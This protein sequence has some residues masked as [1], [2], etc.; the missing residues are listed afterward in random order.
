MATENLKIY[1][2][3]KKKKKTGQIH[4]LKT[5]KTAMNS[6][7]PEHTY[8]KFLTP[9]IENIVNLHGFEYVY[10]PRNINVLFSQCRS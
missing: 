8:L 1:K 9:C 10:K 7:W 6:D 2:A 5:I 3:K 4:K